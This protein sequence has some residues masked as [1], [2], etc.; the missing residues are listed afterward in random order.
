MK[1]SKTA[2]IL[3]TAVSEVHCLLLHNLA[4]AVNTLRARDYAVEKVKN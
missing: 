3:G 4:K 1:T 2:T